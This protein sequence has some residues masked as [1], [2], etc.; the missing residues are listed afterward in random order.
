M[1]RTSSY[2]TIG[3]DAVLQIGPLSKLRS[4]KL[5]GAT[6]DG[7]PAYIGGPDMVPIA[8]TRGIEELET[9]GLN[10]G[11]KDID[12]ILTAV[13]PTESSDGNSTALI[14]PE[15][16]S[17]LRQ[18]S[19]LEAD[20]PSFGALREMFLVYPSLESLMI[21]ASVFEDGDR[22]NAGRQ[23]VEFT[24]YGNVLREF[25]AGLRWFELEPAVGDDELSEVNDKGAIGS[26]R[27][28]LVRLEQLR[29]PLAALVG[30]GLDNDDDSDNDDDESSSGI[31]RL[32]LSALLPD[33][34][35]WFWTTISTE[36]NMDARCAA[37]ERMLEESGSGT[38]RLPLLEWVLVRITTDDEAPMESPSPLP[39]PLFQPHGLEVRK[40]DE[41]LIMFM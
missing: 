36:G 12:S 17:S 18:L 29:L 37:L 40:L 6:A 3:G 34:L 19:L 41:S 21:H 8:L 35:R 10:W 4:L 14:L 38:K 27:N 16:R 22:D 15:S 26:L 30:T 9:R 2:S 20:P 1:T 7:N 13:T 23:D 31:G 39:R 25:R 5:A 11:H 24:A 33:S 28:E 32:D